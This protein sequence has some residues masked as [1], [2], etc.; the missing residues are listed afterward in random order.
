MNSEHKIV[1]GVS[2]GDLNGIGP[3][4]ALRSFDNEIMKSC[5]AIF[6]A[7]KEDLQYIARNEGLDLTINPI[8]A[9]HEAKPDVINVVECWKDAFRFEHGKESKEAGNMAILS[10]R[11]AV[12]SLRNSNIDVLVTAPINKRN[13]QSED[14]NFPGH[15]NF[16]AYELNEEPLMFMVH[17]DIKIGL[18]T[19]HVPLSKVSETITEDLVKKKA[20]LLKNSL[21]V[22][23]NV[24]EPRIAVLGINPH[25]GDDGVIGNED[26]QILIPAIQN[27]NKEEAFLFGPFP[28]DS[29]FG[30]GGYKK[31]DAILA[32]Y[33]DQGLIPFKTLSFGKGVNYTAGLSKIR[34]SPDHGTAYEIAG[35]GMANHNSFKEAVLRAISI[36]LNRR[37]ISTK[38]C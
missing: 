33:H 19:D 4:V 17:D 22:D 32:S 8:Y 10:L 15:T 28:A 6:Y 37:R 7:R 36:Y 23:F 31:Y 34:T 29:F 12:A 1:V 5:I 20:R 26:Q 35:K 2:I 3:E 9:E 25:V 24:K 27:I 18:L 11:R 14:F 30:S 38:K 21:K 16:I 13:I